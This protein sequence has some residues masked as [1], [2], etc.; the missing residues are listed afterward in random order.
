MVQKYGSGT[1][2]YF[3]F[4]NKWPLK[5]I[6][7]NLEFSSKSIIKTLKSQKVMHEF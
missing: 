6:T 1:T 7:K 5:L 4:F 3:Y 2:G